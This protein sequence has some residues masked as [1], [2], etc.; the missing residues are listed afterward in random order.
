MFETLK[1]KT[2]S[3]HCVDWHNYVLY[4]FD[5]RGVWMANGVL[6]V[7]ITHSDFLI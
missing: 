7:S 6:S 1:N 2:K 4:I 5:Q 3:H